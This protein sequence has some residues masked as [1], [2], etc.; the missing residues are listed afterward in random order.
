[1]KALVLSALLTAA[2][3]TPAVAAALGCACATTTPP[4][5]YEGRFD[6]V[7]GSEA[8][9]SWM[10]AARGAEKVECSSLKTFVHGACT[11]GTN[12]PTTPKP[13]EL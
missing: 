13:L 2:R 9:G 3:Y 8:E 11:C 7:D 5:A 12:V 1:M 6:F 10:C 4:H